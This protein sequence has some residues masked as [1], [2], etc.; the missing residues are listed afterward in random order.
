MDK[1]GFTGTTWQ[2]HANCEWTWPSVY[3]VTGCT[4]HDEVFETPTDDAAWGVLPAASDHLTDALGAL[5]GA[6]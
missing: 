4:D 6:K 3:G 1:T 5:R 2:E